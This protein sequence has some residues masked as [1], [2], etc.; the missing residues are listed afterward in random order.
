MM[1]AAVSHHR[2]V[3]V[4]GMDEPEDRL[5]EGY[6]CADEDRE[7]DS[8]SRPPQATGAAQEEGDPKRD[9]GEC[10]PE[11]VDQVGEERDAQHEDVEGGLRSR[12]D[13]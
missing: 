1:P 5:D 10:V 12:R 13:C 4:L 8:E 3:S 6:N 2:C 9:R 7:D 11:V